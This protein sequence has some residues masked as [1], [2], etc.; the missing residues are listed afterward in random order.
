MSTTRPITS[1]ATAAPST[2]RASVV[3]RARRSPNTRAVMPT[4]VAVSAAPTNSAVL[5]SS[6]I[7]P[8]APMPEDH[9]RDHADRGDQHRR[10]AD[11][12]ELARGPSPCRPRAAAGSRPISPSVRRTSSPPPTALSTDGP[13]RMPATISPTTAGTPM[14]SATSAATLAATRTMRMWR[15]ISAM[16][17]GLG[18]VGRTGRDAHRAGTDV[19]C[20]P[21]GVDGGARLR[22]RSQHG[23]G[24]VAGARRRCGLPPPTPASRRWPISGS[25]PRWRLELGVGES[26]HLRACP[27]PRSPS[28]PA[29][30]CRPS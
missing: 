15:R 22:A 30:G 6:P 12:A 1:S 26:A 4:L 27:C 7:S 8:I 18:R 29:G 19:P 11:L 17:M 16:S 24:R 25:E 14:R 20:P 23:R 13:M 10:P 21:G 2:M 3:A 28:R 5:K 9:R